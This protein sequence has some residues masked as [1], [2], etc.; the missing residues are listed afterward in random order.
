MDA[1]FYPL[2]TLKNILYADT[3]GSYNLRTVFHT[4]GFLDLYQGIISRLVY[5][6]PVL[7]GIY[8]TTQTGL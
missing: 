2:D 4:T 6:L 3:L 5:N 7:S 8:C 1:V